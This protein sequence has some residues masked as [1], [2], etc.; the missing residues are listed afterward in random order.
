MRLTDKFIWGALLAALT[1]ATPA[2]ARDAASLGDLDVPVTRVPDWQAL[3]Y[4]PGETSGWEVVDVTAYGAN[5]AVGSGHNDGAAVRAAYAAATGCSHP[6]GGSIIYLPAGTYEWPLSGEV[7]NLR[8]LKSCVVIQGAGIGATV[9]R[10]TG[11]FSQAVFD[12][13][14]GGTSNTRA[15][16]AGY[17]MGTRELTVANIDGLA[18]GDWVVLRADFPSNIPI[19]TNDGPVYGYI[20]RIEG[21][22]GNRVTL[23]RPLKTDF[24]TGGQ[25]LSKLNAL[26]SVGLE[27]ITIQHMQPTTIRRYRQP[28]GFRGTVESWVSNVHLKNWGSRLVYVDDD[29]ARIAIRDNI[30]EGQHVRPEDPPAW[31]KQAVHL[32]QVYD[33]VVEN[34]AFIETQVGV[35][36]EFGAGGN[37]VAHNYIKAP[38]GP[39]PCERAIYF[40]GRFPYSNLVEGNH[41]ECSIV[42]DRYWGSQ[43]PFNTM[44][45]NR[46]LITTGP[47]GYNPAH[48]PGNINGNA[49]GLRAATNADLNILAN[50]VNQL[51]GTPQENREIDYTQGVLAYEDMWVERNLVRDSARLDV[52]SGSAPPGVLSSS[53]G[54]P[55]ASG[56]TWL[57]NHVG[58]SSAPASWSGVD[59]PASLVRNAAPSW[60]CQESGAFPNIGAPSDDMTS[61]GRLP[62]QIRWEGSHCTEEGEIVLPPAAPILLD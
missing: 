46:S 13:R 18:I 62:S 42:F 48:M 8:V 37:V 28:V 35:L 34:N 49:D 1:A 38:T 33:S 53:S 44:F 22:S 61:L 59:I 15:W 3:D 7:G 24:G 32:R 58:G 60:W 41:V 43:G 2:L 54:A 5:P 21:F 23:D 51:R 52:S 27:D 26:R 30:I 47:S 39:W 10:A 36:M 25:T 29:S 20:A 57:D 50:N 6:G 19:T 17:T 12:F 11:T 40:H 56:T 31:N 14:G 45:R 16:T 9:I 4:L 55:Y